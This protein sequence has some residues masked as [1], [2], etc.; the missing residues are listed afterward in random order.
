MQDP[1]DLREQARKCRVLAKIAN[2]PEVIE[3]LRAWSVELAD[4][5]RRG[6]AH[7]RKGR[8]SEL[9]LKVGPR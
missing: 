5:S 6:G 3:Q 7:R 9:R 8:E 1:K 4:P 2:D